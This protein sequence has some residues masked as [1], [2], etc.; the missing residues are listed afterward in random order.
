MLNQ[1]DHILIDERIHSSQV[2]VRSFREAGYDTLWW[3]RMLQREK[4]TVSK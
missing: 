2:H 1:T 3:L 4:V